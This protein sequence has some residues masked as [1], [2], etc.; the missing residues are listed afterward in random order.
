MQ[1]CGPTRAGD[2]VR[3]QQGSG[4]RT[5]VSP[6]GPPTPR[7]ARGMQQRAQ[8]AARACDE[9]WD[10]PTTTA[11]APGTSCSARHPLAEPG[12][13]S[14]ALRKGSQRGRLGGGTRGPPGIPPILKKDFLLPHKETNLIPFTLRYFLPAV[15]GSPD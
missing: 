14:E 11:A 5:P 9:Q 2:G 13:L 7:H 6:P 4:E 12:H 15:W 1:A 3:G 10:L 8:E